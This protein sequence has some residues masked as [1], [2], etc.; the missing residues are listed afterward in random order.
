M[1]DL[2]LLAPEWEVVQTQL[3]LNTSPQRVLQT[4]PRRF[5]VIFCY[6][7]NPS[8]PDAFVNF[9]FL[10]IDSNPLHFGIIVKALEVARFDFS[11][12]AAL[13]QREWWARDSGT[14]PS[15]NGSLLMTEIIQ[16]AR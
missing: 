14:N 13:V 5:S 3:T 10:T 12:V 6:F 16:S 8:P 15:L 1:I 7:N 11:H 9:C 2:S 4:N